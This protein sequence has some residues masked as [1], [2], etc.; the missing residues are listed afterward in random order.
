MVELPADHTTLRP[1]GPGGRFLAHQDPAARPDPTR[2]IRRSQ[3][4]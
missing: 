1:G 4:C 2:D 3:D